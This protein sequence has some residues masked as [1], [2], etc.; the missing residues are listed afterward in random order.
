MAA[1]KIAA[2]YED[3]VLEIDLPKVAEVKPKKITVATGK[4]KEKT[5]K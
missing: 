4:K 2:T 5:D 3:G 1:E